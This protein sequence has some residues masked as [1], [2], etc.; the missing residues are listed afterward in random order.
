MVLQ[1]LALVLVTMVMFY[2][3]EGCQPDLVEDAHNLV[4]V[5]YDRQRTTAMYVDTLSVDMKKKR[6]CKQD[7]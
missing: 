2:Q 4:T 5:G 7:E 3:A 6:I 1:R